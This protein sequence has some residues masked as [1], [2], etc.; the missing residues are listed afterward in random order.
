M[1][2]EGEKKKKE[3]KDNEGRRG[4]GGREPREKGK[5]DG[6]DKENVVGGQREGI[7]GNNSFIC[8]FLYFLHQTEQVHSQEVQ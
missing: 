2:E 5:S 7:E 4:R 6:E 3:V 8:L 1:G